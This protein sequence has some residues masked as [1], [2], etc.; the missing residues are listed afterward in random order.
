MSDTHPQLVSA[1]MDPSF[2]PHPAADIKLI[3][4]HISYIFLA[5]ELVYKVKKPVDFGF[6]NF[7]TL[8]LRR[9]Y[10]LEELRLN[11]RLAP[12]TYIAVHP[13]HETLSGDLILGEPLS[14]APVSGAA[15]E[16]V[17]AAAG[18]AE[19]TAKA[20]VGVA[21]AA[22]EVSVTETAELRPAVPSAIGSNATRVMDY[23]LKMR[24]L[25]EE[26]ML[27]HLLSMGRVGPETMDAI[28]RKVAR[29]HREA[30]TGGEVDQIG[31]VASIQHN[32]TEN[33][34]QTK[35]YRNITIPKRMFSFIRA[36]DRDFF[37]RHISFLENRVRAGRVRDC[38]GDLHLEHIC[39]AG[40]D[41]GITIFDCI[42]FNQ[43]FRYSDVAC[44]VAFLYMDLDFNG[45]TDL[46]EDFVDA[47]VEASGDKGVQELLSFFA[48]YRAYVRGKVISF[49]LDDV[50]IVPEDRE[51]ARR[52]AGRYFALAYRYA[53]RFEQPTM[54]LVGG[55]MGTGKSTLAAAIADPLGAEVVR[56]DVMRKQL[57][58]IPEDMRC[59]DDF[60]SGLYSRDM[61]ERTYA[62][63]LD[64]SIAALREG[65]SVII[66]ASWSRRADRERAVAVALNTGADVHFVECVCPEDVVRARLDARMTQVGEASDG[67][68]ELF[69]AQRDAYEPVIADEGLRIIRIDCSQPPDD[70]AYEAVERLRIPH[71]AVDGS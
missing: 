58:R 20:A 51:E 30:E 11:R 54:V 10:C 62:A 34:I 12:D 13:I 7:T 23:A 35:K 15:S 43:R 63:S 70:C 17:G 41:D 1:M 33:F 45:Y 46:A 3:Q 18:L 48:C 8:D 28:A 50:A 24:R 14:A 49:R 26:R 19:A 40:G 31:G 65:R 6:L 4:T 69:A 52:I 44:E 2:Y 47:Y 36:Y 60:G 53:A 66:D 21:E 25:P 67:R 61:T 56:T 5:G 64:R 27:K 39:L 42:E 71:S 9:H 38:H 37:A 55:L 16:A 22:E 68:W 57:A 29:F 32:N 59:Y